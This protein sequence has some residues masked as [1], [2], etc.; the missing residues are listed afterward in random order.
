M[1]LRR[2]HRLR[3][4]RHLLYS[5]HLHLHLHLHQLLNLRRHLRPSLNQHLHRLHDQPQPLQLRRERRS[6]QMFR[7]NFCHQLCVV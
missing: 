1:R 2:P 3:R 7:T 4:L 5:L 6:L